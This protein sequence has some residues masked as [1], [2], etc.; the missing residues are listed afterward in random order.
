METTL[1]L[2]QINRISHSLGINFYHAMISHNKRD[3]ILPAEFYRN[4]YQVESDTTL[5]EL[6]KKKYAIKQRRM[7]L[8]YYFITD[9]GIEVFRKDFSKIIEYVPKEKRGL[10]YLRQR[11]NLYCKFHNYTFGADHIL[12]EYFNKFAKK[13]YVSHTTKDTINTFKAE[14]KQYFKSREKKAVQASL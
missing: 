4:Y 1:S 3:K 2:S 12:D 11:I 13:I 8:Q 6:V 7:N 10:A 5:D 14:L 9:L